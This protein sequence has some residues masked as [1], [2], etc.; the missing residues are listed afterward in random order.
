M[1]FQKSTLK[2]GS[3]LITV[4]LPKS[5]SATFMIFS[6]SGPMFDPLGKT[7][8]S[9]FVEHLFF[10]G[11]AKYPTSADLSRALE[12]YGAVS[13]S[14][15]Y[16]ETNTYWAKIPKDNLEVAVELLTQQLQYSLFRA[17]DIESEK[18]VVKEELSM[19]KSNPSSYIWE[20][21]SENIWSGNALG[22][23]YTGSLADI[24]SFTKDDVSNFI[25]HNY[26]SKNTVFVISGD[27]KLNEA[28]LLMD[29]HLMNY[30]NKSDQKMPETIAIREDPIKTDS[31]ETDTITAAYGFLTTNCSDPDSLR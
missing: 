21:W 19:V 9:H 25:K 7:G 8:L 30:S 26:T 14:F 13:E 18:E 17:E 24:N 20:L 27:I 4:E 15:S 22:R 16:Q 23:I 28:K 2:N 3:T 29:K 11:T 31:Y 1:S 10:K 12:K 5:L 6:R